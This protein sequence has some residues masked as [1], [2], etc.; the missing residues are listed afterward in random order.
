MS[1]L[2]KIIAGLLA[3]IG[4]LAIV[5]AILGRSGARPEAGLQSLVLALVLAAVAKLLDHAAAIRKQLDH[6][7]TQVDE[8]RW[9]RGRTSG[10]P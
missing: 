4:V 3:V 1:I 6:I 7:Q 9:D 10:Q 5:I 2:L 8:I